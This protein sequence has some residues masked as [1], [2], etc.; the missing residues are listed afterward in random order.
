MVTIYQKQRQNFDITGLVS[1]INRDIRRH[2]MKVICNI[3]TKDMQNKPD[4]FALYFGDLVNGKIYD[5]V[6]IEKN[7]YRIIDG[8]NE[9]YLYPPE[10]FEVVET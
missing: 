1:R 6:S 3:E 7:W 10:L 2:T 8:S 9:D 4:S 5:V